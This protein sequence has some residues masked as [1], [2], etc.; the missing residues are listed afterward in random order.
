MRDLKIQ[1]V[2]V[3]RIPDHMTLYVHVFNYSV[4]SKHLKEDHGIIDT[5]QQ[6]VDL[7]AEVSAKN[8]I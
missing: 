3:L 7:F 4:M 5:Y 8:R 1:D 6:Q 2:D